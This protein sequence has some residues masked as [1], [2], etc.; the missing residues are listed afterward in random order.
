MN[1][2]SKRSFAGRN[3]QNTVNKLDDDGTLDKGQAA[4]NALSGSGVGKGP[5]KPNANANPNTNIG[6]N[7]QKMDF[8]MNPKKSSIDTNKDKKNL[9]EVTNVLYYKTSMD[10]GYYFN[11]IFTYD[12]NASYFRWR[13]S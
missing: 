5:V 12:N 10:F 8:T 1:D 9:K 3:I 2:I 7:K 6:N 11:I 4:M 13:W